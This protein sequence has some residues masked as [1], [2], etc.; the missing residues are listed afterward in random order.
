MPRSARAR[1]DLNLVVAHKTT[2]R[3]GGISR[4]PFCMHLGQRRNRGG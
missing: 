1:L 2:V 3:L 4:S